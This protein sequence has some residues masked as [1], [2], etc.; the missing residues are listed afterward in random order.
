MNDPVVA[1]LTEIRDDQR[2]LIKA[3]LLE[4]DAPTLPLPCAHPAESR[5]NLS[6]MGETQW[7]WGG[8]DC[9]FMFGPVPK[10]GDHAVSQ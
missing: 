8:K 5:I 3:L 9:G 1:L 10:G 2:A 4:P 6:A 7:R